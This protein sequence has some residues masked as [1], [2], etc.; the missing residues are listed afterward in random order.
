MAGGWIWISHI[1]TPR[2]QTQAT[3]KR[4]KRPCARTYQHGKV[5]A[6]YHGVGDGEG[7]EVEVAEVAGEGLA[8]EVHGGE[9]QVHEDGRAD[10]APQLLGLLPHL[11]R[12]QASLELAS[13]P[14]LLRRPR[15]L[16]EERD[17]ALALHARS[18]QSLLHAINEAC[19]SP[20]TQLGDAVRCEPLFLLCRDCT[21]LPSN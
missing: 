9:H 5:E 18:R 19:S 10:D 20:A 7:G 8:D 13:F 15:E 6:V 21:A 11:L 2:E 3:S 1:I 17:L 14:L 4:K 16:R 12:Q